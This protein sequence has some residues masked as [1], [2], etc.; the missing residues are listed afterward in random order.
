MAHTSRERC[1]RIE[2]LLCRWKMRLQLYDDDAGDSD[3]ACA[4]AVSGLSVI[5]AAV[6]SL[7][8]L[9]GDLP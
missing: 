8:G 4:I 5:E 9:T 6:S 1:E 7:V 2:T 3:L